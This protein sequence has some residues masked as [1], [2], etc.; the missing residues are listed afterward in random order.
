MISYSERSEESKILQSSGASYPKAI[1]IWGFW[2]LGMRL[3][4]TG[5]ANSVTPN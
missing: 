2:I 1:L 4:M 5:L 3:G